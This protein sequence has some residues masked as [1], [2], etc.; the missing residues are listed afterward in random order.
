MRRYLWNLFIAWDQGINTL[1]GGDPDETLSSRV[2]R[3]SLAGKRW[4]RIAERIIDRLFE[5]L[6]EGPGHCRRSIEWDVACR[7]R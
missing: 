4:A 7:G 5:L 3:A 6:G 1:L 2:G